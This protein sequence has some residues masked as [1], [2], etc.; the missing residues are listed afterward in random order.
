MK[1]DEQQTTDFLM[2]ELYSYDGHAEQTPCGSEKDGWSLEKGEEWEKRR[3]AT[4]DCYL[5]HPDPWRHPD[6]ILREKWNNIFSLQCPLTL[7]TKSTLHRY[8]LIQS[9]NN[10]Q[11]HIKGDIWVAS[12]LQD[13]KVWAVSGL[14]FML[15]LGGIHSPASYILVQPDA[16]QGPASSRGA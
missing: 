6:R 11:T 7:W 8:M 5:R 15:S 12:S 13:H 10:K 9:S 2:T 4:G 1:L 14:M 3:C 16:F